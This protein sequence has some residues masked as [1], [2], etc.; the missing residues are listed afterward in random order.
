MVTLKFETGISV[1]FLQV[2]TIADMTGIV[3]KNI[4]VEIS[5]GDCFLQIA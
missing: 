2:I 5:Q 1:W 4:W 3:Y